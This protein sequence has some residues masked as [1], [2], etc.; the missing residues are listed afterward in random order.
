[1]AYRAAVIKM[2][3]KDEK[4]FMEAKDQI[5][6]E[7]KKLDETIVLDR[8]RRLVEFLKAQKSSD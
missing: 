5:D 7:V 6:D 2:L 1:V 4:I 3:E 8:K